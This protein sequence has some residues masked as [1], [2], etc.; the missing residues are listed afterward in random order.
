MGEAVFVYDVDGADGW[1]TPESVGEIERWTFSGKLYRLRLSEDELVFELA[2]Y[3]GWMGPANRALAEERYELTGHVRELIG[4]YERAI[5]DF[6]FRRLDLPRRELD[7]LLRTL[8]GRVGEREARLECH[9]PVYR[10]ESKGLDLPAASAE[11]SA[12]GPAE[13][14]GTR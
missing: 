14:E 11:P 2:R 1:V 10:L 13:G 5:A 12:G 8:R 4:L 9:R 3:G 7:P 6:T